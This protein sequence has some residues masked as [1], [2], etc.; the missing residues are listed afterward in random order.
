MAELPTAALPVPNRD[1]SSP[2]KQ[3]TP[4][5]Q[6]SQN[7]V[8]A[9]GSS[10]R[11]L[12][13]KVWDQKEPAIPAVPE[14]KLS[15]AQADDFDDLPTRPLATGSPELYIQRSSTTAPMR[16]IQD[17]RVDELERLDTVRLA[18][19][20]AAPPFEQT[21]QPRRGT[22]QQ[23]VNSS[24]RSRQPP[25]QAPV[26]YVRP[27]QA[28]QER[29]GVAPALSVQDL[30][31]T[32]PPQYTVAP[33]KRRKS[34][35]PLLLGLLVLLLLVVGGGATAWI[36]MYQP[37][38][39]PAITQPRQTFNDQQLGLVLQYPSGWHFQNDRGKSSVHFYDSS[40]TAQ[41]NI[42]VSPANGGDPA[43]YLQQEAGQ[44][45]LTGQK[46]GAAL[47]F[48]GA[49]WQQLQGNVQQNGAT[50]TE[51][52]FVTSHNQRF[53]TIMFL[54]PQTIYAQEDQIVFSQI[55]STF[56]FLS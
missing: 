24:Q 53:F 56:Q 2:Q 22:G 12:R 48:A 30:K 55:R 16:K 35:K 39:V 52:L 17:P 36:I 42:V 11:E 8:S 10:L 27:G 37:F 15:S 43:S 29:P 7:D 1:A 51:A 25:D 46:A 33:V 31:Q 4:A 21:A 14:E 44:I 47:M 13:V 40:H 5:D 38:S 20:P 23:Q 32:P 3:T 45:G 6:P 49:S 34:S 41:V 54:A 28:M 26:F 19:Q 50:Y 9:P 18:A